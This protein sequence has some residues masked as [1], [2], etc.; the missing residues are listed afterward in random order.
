MSEPLRRAEARI[1]FSAAKSPLF[2]RQTF[3]EAVQIPISSTL[4]WDEIRRQLPQASL[5]GSPSRLV[6]SGLP[7]VSI[8]LPEEARSL[9]EAL[10]AFS[11][12]NPDVDIRVQIISES[13]TLSIEQFSSREGQV[14]F[15]TSHR[16][17]RSH[18][19]PSKPA[20]R[21]RV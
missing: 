3:A 19:S 10:R 15:F 13:Q 11:A 7:H 12:L 5:P 17:A 20:R 21:P 8:A 16:P 6:V 14:I 9:H 4:T 1:D 2:V 18:R